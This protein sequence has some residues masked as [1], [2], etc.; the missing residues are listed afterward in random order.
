MDYFIRETSLKELFFFLQSL[1][2]QEQ[3][4]QG[5]SELFY[6]YLPPRLRLFCLYESYETLLF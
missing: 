1:N 6:T 3:H 4:S 2:I 5:F